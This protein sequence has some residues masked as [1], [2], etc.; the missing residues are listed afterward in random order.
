MREKALRDVAAAMQEPRRQWN[1]R[2]EAA[3]IA[4]NR[5]SACIPHVMLALLAVHD[6]ASFRAAFGEFV[7]TAACPEQIRLATEAITG[8]A[9]GHGAK[10]SWATNLLKSVPGPGSQQR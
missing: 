8:S 6:R 3:D 1:W 2:Q 10:P 5:Q 9:E 4:V 7:L